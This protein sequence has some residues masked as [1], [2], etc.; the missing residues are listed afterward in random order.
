MRTPAALGLVSSLLLAWQA[1]FL[2]ISSAMRLRPMNNE[3][4]LEED[5]SDTLDETN[6]LMSSIDDEKDVEARISE[7]VT[8][9]P[10]IQD[11]VC[12][13]FDEKAA[14]EAAVNQYVSRCLN[15][16]CAIIDNENH[17]IG[18]KNPNIRLPNKYQLEAI[19]YIFKIVVKSYKKEKQLEGVNFNNKMK[20]ELYRLFLSLL[21]RQNLL[22]RKL[23]KRDVFLS[24]YLYM[25]TLYYKAY[26]AVEE[27]KTKLQNSL[28][29][30]RYLCGNRIKRTL[31]NIV[32][33]NV[34]GSVRNTPARY[35]VE[36]SRDYESYLHQLT[37][38]A[39]NFTH[40]YSKMTI[41]ILIATMAKMVIEAERPWYKKLLRWFTTPIR[42]TFNPFARNKLIP[43]TWKKLKSKLLKQDP[44][45]YDNFVDE[46]KKLF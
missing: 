28:R 12:A 31:K 13:N 33:A 41:D 8:D 29:V 17:P 27:V 6:A 16:N 20:N 5:L 39:E 3:A 32:V 11:V 30:A 4:A 46:T 10:K 42:D 37:P 19:F 14:C 35:I 34:K 45:S 38:K 36:M 24:R 9:N 43:R 1:S 21:M 40:E 2:T 15:T 22:F 44:T 26:T 23:K 7:F 18:G 25:T